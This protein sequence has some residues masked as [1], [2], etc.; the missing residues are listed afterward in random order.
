M[1]AKGT[2]AIAVATFSL[3]L[4]SSVEALYS[5]AAAPEAPRGIVVDKL[6]LSS[7]HTLSIP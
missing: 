7:E 4:H 2:P 5:L 6:D 3:W 1:Y